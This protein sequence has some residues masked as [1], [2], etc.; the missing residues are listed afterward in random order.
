MLRK[1]ASKLLPHHGNPKLTSPP[2]PLPLCEGRPVLVKSKMRSGTHLLIDLILN[3]FPPL[4]T[5]T[6]YVELDHAYHQNMDA[7]QFGELGKCVCK[8]HFSGIKNQKLRREITEK[9]VAQA[10]IIE[11]VRSLEKMKPSL[12]KFLSTEE[13]GEYIDTCQKFD[14]YWAPIDCLKIP[15]EDLISVS[16]NDRAIEL[17]GKYIGEKPSQKRYYNRPKSKAKLVLIEKLLTRLL[18]VRQRR[19]NTTIAFNG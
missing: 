9:V 4:R 16:G 17:I 12:R 2:G 11:P 1:I 7:Q 3:N 14:Q 5:E 19:V 15:F 18:G 6:L 8:T 10:F 13:Y